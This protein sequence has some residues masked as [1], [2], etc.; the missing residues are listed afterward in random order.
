MEL[1]K[2]IETDQHTVIEQSGKYAN[3][4]VALKFN[5]LNHNEIHV[6]KE[7]GLSLD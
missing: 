6:L 4:Q 7:I 2:S 5:A 3:W 1:S